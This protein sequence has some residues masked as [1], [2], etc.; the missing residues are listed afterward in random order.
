[1][2]GK[3]E[4]MERYNSNPVASEITEALLG[5]GSNIYE[6]P[7]ELSCK[8]KDIT[9]GII[10]KQNNM[11]QIEALEDKLNKEYAE[12]GK[13]K[14]YEMSE[15][16]L[17]GMSNINYIKSIMKSIEPLDSLEPIVLA[18]DGYSN[19]LKIVDG[20]HRV[21]K[22]ILENKKEIKSIILESYVITRNDSDTLFGFLKKQIGKSITF[23]EDKVIKIEDVF[24][25]IVPNEGCGGCSNGWSKIEI[26][27][28]FLKKTIKITSVGNIP[29]KIKSIH[30]EN[31]YNEDCYILTINDKKVGLIDTGWGNGYYGGDFKINRIN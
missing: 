3:K 26:N 29:I 17:V 23:V 25:S 30:G 20:Y 27:K 16:E 15:I 6:N 18:K 19:K 4:K 2:F 13:I 8:M 12:I 21:K 10:A 1:M 11:N 7:S 5:L 22:A 28:K 24:Y 14:I 9:D 31:S